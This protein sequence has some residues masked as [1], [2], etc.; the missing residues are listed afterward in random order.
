MSVV[1]HPVLGALTLNPTGGQQP[2]E[3]GTSHTCPRSPRG[4]GETWVLGGGSEA[5]QGGLATESRP[6]PTEGHGGPGRLRMVPA[7]PSFRP[8]PGARGQGKQ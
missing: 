4:P 6:R 7:V 3:L 1:C 5:G 8:H 2:R